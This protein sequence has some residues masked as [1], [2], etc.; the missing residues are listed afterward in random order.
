[1]REKHFLSRRVVVGGLTHKLSI[2]S[3]N[4]GVLTSVEPF[5]EETQNVVYTPG[6]LIVV[7]NVSAAAIELQLSLLIC[8]DEDATIENV[9]KWMNK[10]RSLFACVGK[11]V[12]LYEI[13][14]SKREWRRVI[15]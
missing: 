8:G 10:D 12:S 2:V 15:M 1:M 13:D 11:P 3:L 6:V 9:D 5:S 4:D 7:A 14:C